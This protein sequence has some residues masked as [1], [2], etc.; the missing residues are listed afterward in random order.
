[1]LAPTARV[2]MQPTRPIAAEEELAA[3]ERRDGHGRRTARAMTTA[4]AASPIRSRAVRR[5][6]ST[7]A[8]PTSVR[9]HRRRRSG[10]VVRSVRDGLAA[11]LVAHC[12]TAYEV[13]L[14]QRAR[15]RRRP[16]PSPTAALDEDRD[17]DLRV[18]R[19]REA[20][21]PRV[22]LARA[23]ELGGAGLAGRRDA[24]HLGAGRELP[25][26]LALDRLEHRR[27]DRVGVGRPR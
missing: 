8:G 14:H 11:A 4:T 15:Q 10:V 18:V 6:R 3:D 2:I 20:D 13:C 1:M 7:A 22:R 12:A 21:E 16:G 5:S 24:G 9:R 25:A 19:R 27:G 23:A 17:R 26:E